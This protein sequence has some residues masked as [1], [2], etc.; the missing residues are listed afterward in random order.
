MATIKAFTDISQSKVLAKILPIESADMAYL[1]YKDDGHVVNKSPY[2][3]DGTEVRGD[4][5]LFN[6]VDCWSLAALI[7]VLKPH[8]RRFEISVRVD[9]NYNVF[10]ANEVFRYFNYD[11]KPEGFDNLIDACVTIIEKLYEQNLL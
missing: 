5:G 11:D 10:A 4:D 1:I 7:N 2:V 3:M 8:L 6:Y 9:K